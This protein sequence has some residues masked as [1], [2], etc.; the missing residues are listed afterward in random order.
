MVLHAEGVLSVARN[1]YYRS[2]HWQALRAQAIKRDNGTCVVPGCGS[3]DSISVD[4]IITRPNVDHPTPL[5]VLS[6]IR[7][8][9][10]LHDNQTKEDASGKRRSGGKFKVIGCD[11]NGW[12]K[13]IRHPWQLRK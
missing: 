1:A 13:D 6:N 3:R 12:P 2:L 10:R 11:E 4:H 7:C 9:C 5:D 8:I